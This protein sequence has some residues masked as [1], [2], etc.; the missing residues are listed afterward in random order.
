[1]SGT[2]GRNSASVFRRRIASAQY[3]NAIAPYARICSVAIYAN[4]QDLCA[5]RCVQPF[6]AIEPDLR[7]A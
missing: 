3:A 7:H 1:L 4:R 6:R 5:A 2:A